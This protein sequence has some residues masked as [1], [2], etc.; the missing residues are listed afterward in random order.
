MRTGVRA[1]VATT[2]RGWARKTTFFRGATDDLAT[3]RLPTTCC[4]L[5]GLDLRCAAWAPGA[6]SATPNTAK[7]HNLSMERSAVMDRCEIKAHP[8]AETIVPQCSPKK[9]NAQ[10][11]ALD[12]T[13]IHDCT[14][15]HAQ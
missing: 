9:K 14:A 2:R 5:S 8:Q 10:D 1:E 3:G 6:A 15:F 7:A 11:Q 12:F 13:S 4:F